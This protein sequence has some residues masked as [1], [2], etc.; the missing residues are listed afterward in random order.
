[1][2]PDGGGFA[3]LHSFDT[4]NRLFGSTSQAGVIFGSDG[5]LY[6]GTLY[7]GVYGPPGG[8][9]DGILF[10]MSPGGG[11][12]LKLHD[13]DSASGRGVYNRLVR[14]GSTL[15]GTTWQGGAAD[16]GTVFRINQDGTGFAKLHDFTGANGLA[17]RAGLIVAANGVLYGT[18]E[19]GGAANLGTVYKINP[20]GS[21]FALVHSF[22]GG[23]TGFSPAGLMQASDGSLYGVTVR[24]GTAD[25]GVVYRLCP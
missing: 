18:T 6:G 25:V 1:V 15:Y 24:G 13:F 3:E 4:S 8:V 20:D 9:H 21:G 22:G 17:P 2:T 5:A 23:A 7:G 16:Q 19:R 12:F 11:G 10:K 14:I